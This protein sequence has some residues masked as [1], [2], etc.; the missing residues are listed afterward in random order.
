MHIK[1]VRVKNPKNVIVQIPGF[2]TEKWNLQIDDGVEM[3]VSEDA[4][5][6]TLI[7]RKGYVQVSA[8]S[9]VNESRERVVIDSVRCESK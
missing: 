9:D 8:R 6:V 3:H 1:T 4:K 5:S 2:L 7:P